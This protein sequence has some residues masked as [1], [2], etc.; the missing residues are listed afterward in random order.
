MSF[1]EERKFQQRAAGVQPSRNQNEIVPMHPDDFG[2]HLAWITAKRFSESARRE[3]FAEKV[4]IISDF[5]I[6]EPRILYRMEKIEK[7]CGGLSV[8]KSETVLKK[9]ELPD[10]I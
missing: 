5:R 6:N 9:Y 4:H 10:K 3:P 2:A 8:C 7:I 1:P